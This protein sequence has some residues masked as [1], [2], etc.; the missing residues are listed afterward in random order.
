MKVRPHRLREQEACNARH[1]RKMGHSFSEHKRINQEYRIRGISPYEFFRLQRKNARQRAIEWQFTFADWWKV[2]LDSG[3]W[4]ERGNRAGQF[5][6][7]RYGDVGPYSASN[8]RILTHNQNS[9][10]AHGGS[11][12]RIDAVAVIRAPGLP[13][14]RALT[15]ALNKAGIKRKAWEKLVYGETLTVAADKAAVLFQYCASTEA[16]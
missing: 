6:M 11:L 4:F 16:A 9:A 1:L 8:V 3:K 12:D 7:A 10:E 5:V 14:G 13:S 15:S 2:W